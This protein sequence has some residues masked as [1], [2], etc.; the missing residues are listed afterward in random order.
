TDTL[1][2]SIRA[3][4][5]L[6]AGLH[7]LLWI[8]PGLHEPSPTLVGRFA[9]SLEA[10]RAAIGKALAG[11]YAAAME[12]NTREVEGALGYPYE[13]LR[14]RLRSAGA[15]AAGVSG[16]GPTL[17]VLTDAGQRHRIQEVLETEIGTV[18]EVPLRLR[19]A[20]VRPVGPPEPP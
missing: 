18:R 20:A 13:H 2:Q 15:T 12:I 16:M 5:D 8:P 19:G 9:G 6:D 10:G 17:A 3:E 4:G 1:N 11:A 14:R 7:V